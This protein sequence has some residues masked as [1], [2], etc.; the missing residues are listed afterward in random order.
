MWCEMW[1]GRGKVGAEVMLILFIYF[2]FPQKPTSYCIHHLL[3]ATAFFYSF[4]PFFVV[5]FVFSF[6][7]F[8]FVLFFFDEGYTLHPTT[9]Q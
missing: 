5:F 1:R 9:Q 8:V 4:Y 3:D 7:F 6:L 2:S